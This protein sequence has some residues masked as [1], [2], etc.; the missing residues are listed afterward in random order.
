MTNSLLSTYSRLAH[1]SDI[2]SRCHKVGARIMHKQGQFIVIPTA[3]AL[4]RLSIFAQLP[5]T[6]ATRLHMCLEMLLLLLELL[7]EK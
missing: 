7:R 6:T 2:T 4:N 1:N 3:T 5:V